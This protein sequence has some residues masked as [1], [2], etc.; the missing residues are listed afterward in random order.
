[1]SAVKMAT[2]SYRCIGTLGSYSQCHSDLEPPRCW[3]WPC[4]VDGDVLAAWPPPLV[5]VRPQ[6]GVQRH[7]VEQ[8]IETF[9]LVQVLDA[10]VPQMGTQVVDFMQKIDTPSLVEQVITVPKISLDRIPRSSAVRRPQKAE[11]LVEVLTILSFSSLQQQ[12]AEQ[13]IDIP[14]PGRGG[15]GGRRGL[16]GF[17]SGQNST[18]RLV[19]QNVGIHVKRGGLQDLPDPGGSSSFAVS[20][21][22]AGHVVFR[23]FCR[24]KK[25]S[26]VRREFECGAA[27]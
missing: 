17:S 13:I 6:S 24:V 4:D 14:V 23:T 8:I 27:W 1:M 21:E 22:E 5:E 9:V 10:L 19:E 26:E 12:T 18:A 25:K 7:T 20:R 3:S 11:Q 15:G 2:A 16:Q